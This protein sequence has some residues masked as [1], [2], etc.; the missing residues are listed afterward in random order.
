M[1]VVLCSIGWDVAAQTWLGAIKPAQTQIT[2]LP[3]ILGRSSKQ[4]GGD[5]LLFEAKE[6]NIFVE[7]SLGRCIKGTWGSWDLEK[8]TVIHLTFYPAKPRRLSSYKL[9]TANMREE[10]F[11][12]SSSFVNDTAGFL[13]VVNGGRVRE[14]SYFPALEFQSLRCSEQ[15]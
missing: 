14:I 3:Q 7:Y 10:S 8:G 1:C 5:G 11:H 9:P 12:G 6:G 2:D 15:N 13:F 4:R